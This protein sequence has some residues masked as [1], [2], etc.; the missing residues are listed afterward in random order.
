MLRVSSYLYIV[1]KIEIKKRP[2]AINTAGRFNFQH[3]LVLFYCYIPSE[4]QGIYFL[5]ITFAVFL[6]IICHF[7]VTLLTL[8]ANCYCGIFNWWKGLKR[9][10]SVELRNWCHLLGWMPGGAIKRN[11]ARPLPWY[12]WN[13]W[14]LPTWELKPIHWFGFPICHRKK[15]WDYA[16][17]F[18]MQLLENT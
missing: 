4:F 5:I 14:L 10:V 3:M 1:N 15:P 13:T 16:N 18:Q 7:L 2:L 12:V 17:Q 8:T 6:C 9:E 11:R